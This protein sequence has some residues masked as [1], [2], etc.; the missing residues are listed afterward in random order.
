MAYGAHEAVSA[1]R[2]DARRTCTHKVQDEDD[3]LRA[4]VHAGGDNVAAARH[5]HQHAHARQRAHRHSLV[6]RE[7]ARVA[8][9]QPP[10][11]EDAER[12]RRVHRRVHADGQVARVLHDDRRVQVLETGFRPDAVL[13]TQTAVSGGVWVRARV[14]FGQD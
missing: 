7:P 6:L 12:H 1:T 13:Q 8:R 5:Q 3:H 2:R 4:T 11:G 14:Q 9:A 10:L